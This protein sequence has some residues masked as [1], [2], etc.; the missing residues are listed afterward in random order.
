L[1]K[2]A[3]E[4]DFLTQLGSE[5]CAMSEVSSEEILSCNTGSPDFDKTL[6]MEDVSTNVG[7]T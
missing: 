4:L 6:A 5:D 7:K 2:E 1:E 3:R